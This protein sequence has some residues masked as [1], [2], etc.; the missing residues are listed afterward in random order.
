MT[1]RTVRSRVAIITTFFSIYYIYSINYFSFT[2]VALLILIYF[3][4]FC[5]PPV[6]LTACGV[7]SC[8]ARELVQPHRNEK[9]DLPRPAVWRVSFGAADDQT[10]I[11]WRNSWKFKLC[12]LVRKLDILMVDGFVYICNWR[13][14]VVLKFGVTKHK[15]PNVLILFIYVYFLIVFFFLKK[16]RVSNRITIYVCENSGTCLIPF[17]WQII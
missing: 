8:R 6:D 15:L 4:F 14:F 13:Q 17:D 2:S 16:Y 5:F 11:T 12:D 9:E 10:K 7:F 1:D 3:Y